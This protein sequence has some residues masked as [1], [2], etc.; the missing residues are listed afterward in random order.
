MKKKV[1]KNFAILFEAVGHEGS[2]I[3]MLSLTDE[4]ILRLTRFKEYEINSIKTL[5]L[6]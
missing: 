5:A 4:R 2:L 3:K 6:E 1:K